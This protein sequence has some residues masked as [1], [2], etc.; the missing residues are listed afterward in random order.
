MTIFNN[1]LYVTKGSGGNGINTVYQ[2]GTQGP[3]RR[4]RRRILRR[5][6]LRF[7]RDSPTLRRAPGRRFLSGS[8]LPMP[9]LCTFATR[10]MERWYACG[11]RKRGGCAKPGDCRPA[12]IEPGEWDV[13]HA[14]RIAEWLEHWRALQRCEL[15]DGAESRHRR[16]PEYDR[17]HNHDGTVTIFAILRPSAPME[18]RAP[19]RTN[20]LR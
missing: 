2:V 1:T 20:W 10:A 3:C 17:R 18:T 12:E 11:Q 13:D 6:R 19:T 16:L 15:S 9:T 8:G 7:C 14:L 5:Y 4:V